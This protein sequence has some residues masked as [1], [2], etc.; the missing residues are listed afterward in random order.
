VEDGD[1]GIGIA[2]IDVVWMFIAVTALVLIIVGFAIR[3]MRDIT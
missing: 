3:W 2:C 1:E